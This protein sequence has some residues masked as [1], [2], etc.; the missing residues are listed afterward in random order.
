MELVKEFDNKLL[1]RKEVEYIE[2]SST[3]TLG[4]QDA[5]AQVAKALGADENLIVITKIGSHFG[6]QDVTVLAYV[7]ENEEAMN[8]LTPEHIAKR[9]AVE[10]AS[11]E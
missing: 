8:K 10:A 11:E 5:K 6:S 2:K 3:T 7:Y 1:M 9:N 4:R